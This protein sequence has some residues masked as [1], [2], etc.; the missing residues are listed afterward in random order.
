M[1]AGDVSKAMLARVRARLGEPTAATWTDADLYGYLN[2]A[3]S[4][5]VARRLPD[6]CLYAFTEIQEGSWQ[7]DT[8]GYNLPTDFLRERYVEVGGKPCPRVDHQDIRQ[9]T[10]NRLKTATRDNPFYTFNQGQIRFYTGGQNPTTP[11][12]R[13][14][15]VK[16]PAAAQLSTSVD[17]LAPAALWSLMEE[18]A[19]AQAR[20]QGRNLQESA[21][22]Q[23]RYLTRCAVVASRYSGKRPFDAVSGDPR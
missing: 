9:L 12:Y 5:L 6:G 22:L 11:T 7:T 23:K 2:E 4:D 17:P 3:Q 19:V 14:F 8:M 1:A 21:R 13:I 10:A 20:L 18:Y 15:Y 16:K